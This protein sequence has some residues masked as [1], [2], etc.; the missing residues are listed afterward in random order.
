MGGE[1]NIDLANKIIEK[2]KTKN[3]G[4]YS[5]GGFTYAVK[6]NRFV[7]FSDHFGNIYQIAGN[8]NTSIGKVDRSD[9]RK[10]LNRLLGEL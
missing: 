3:D 5:I 4:V 7:L 1:V 2:A 6:N 10:E 8:F 9:I